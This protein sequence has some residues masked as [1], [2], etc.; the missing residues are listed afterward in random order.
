ME[1]RAV[2]EV[3]GVEVGVGVEVE[4]EVEASDSTVE[5]W[6]AIVEALRAVAAVS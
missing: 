5:R 1:S 4:G 3:V 2:E 6:Q